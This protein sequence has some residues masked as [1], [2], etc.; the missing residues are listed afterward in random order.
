MDLSPIFMALRKRLEKDKISKSDTLTRKVS[1]ILDDGT[2]YPFTGTLEFRDISVDPSTGSVTLRL[3][4]P[5][6]KLLLLPNMFVRAKVVEGINLKAILVP[7]QA[8][9]YTPK[10]EA[11]VFTVNQENKVEQKLITIDRSV[12]NKWLISSGLKAGDRLL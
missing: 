11:T 5:N 3:V 12:G 9:V 2:I 4:F 6:P 8:V 1:L 10:S 7:Q